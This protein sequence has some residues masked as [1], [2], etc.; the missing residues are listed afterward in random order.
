MNK[1][2]LI[3]PGSALLLS[4]GVIIILVLFLWVMEVRNWLMVYLPPGVTLIVANKWGRFYWWLFVSTCFPT[5]VIISLYHSLSSWTY[6]L[7]GKIVLVANEQLG[8][9]NPFRK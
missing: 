1:P 7:F 5:G 3:D 6:K 4:T 2:G 8:F 9:A